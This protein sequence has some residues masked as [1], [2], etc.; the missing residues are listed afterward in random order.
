MAIDVKQVFGFLCNLFWIQD[1]EKT[2]ARIDYLEFKIYRKVGGKSTPLEN[3]P[4]ENVVLT[5]VNGQPRYV[6]STGFTTGV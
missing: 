6:R 4:L 1:Y 2:N 5:S 3:R